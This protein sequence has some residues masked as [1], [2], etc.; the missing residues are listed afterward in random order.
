MTTQDQALDKIRK[1]LAKAEDPSVTA[2]EAEAFNTKA[3]ELI[4]AYGIDRAML[5][6][7]DPATDI[8]G[9][10][11]IVVDPPYAMDKAQL[12]H[13]V[14]LALR[15]KTVRRQRHE[16]GRTVLSL[17]LFGFA[18]DLERTE[19]VYTSLLI[20]AVHGMLAAGTPPWESLA[21]YRRSWLAGFTQAVSARLAA[22]ERRAEHQA[23][24][25]RQDGPSVA[26]VLV[27]RAERVDQMVT[28]AYPRLRQ[29]QARYL[30]GS[31]RSQGYAAGQAADLGAT[32]IRPAASRVIGQGGS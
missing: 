14:A 28:A 7:A 27:T 20:Q 26:L 11:I 10:K 32:R 21:A 17:H 29:G 23:S 30:S 12:L 5:A 15:C 6:S 18:S 2:A 31:G 8:P 25:D 1:L 16:H 24:A 9:D 19:L 22:A 3:A 4:A 13:A